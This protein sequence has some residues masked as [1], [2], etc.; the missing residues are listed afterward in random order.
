MTG[1]GLW[2]PEIDEHYYV[3]HDA[4]HQNTDQVSTGSQSFVKSITVIIEYDCVSSFQY[5]MAHE[6]ISMGEVLRRIRF[7]FHGSC[8]LMFADCCFSGT[9]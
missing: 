3:Q 5:P 6:L 4:P 1:H 8:V 2:D 7:G 9:A